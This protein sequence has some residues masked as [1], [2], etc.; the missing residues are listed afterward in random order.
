MN[1]TV[2]KTAGTGENPSRE[3][4]AMPV[5]LTIAGSDSGGGAGIQA[6][7]KTFEAFGVFGC[8]AITVLTAQNSTGVQAIHP[9]PVPFVLAQIE[10]VLTDFDVAAIKLGMLYNQE[11]I[12]A[13]AAIIKP[14]T[15]PVVLDPVCVSKAGSPLIQKEAIAAL[16]DL[17]RVVTLSTPNQHEANRLFGYEGGE[18]DLPAILLDHPA[19]VLIKHHTTETMCADMLYSGA[20]KRVYVADLID[21]TSVHGT[22]CSYSSAI[23]AS[24]ALG[25]DLDAAIRRSKQFITEAIRYAPA[26]GHGRGPINHKQGGIHLAERTLC[27][28]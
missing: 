4:T 8:S 27:H 16:R 1:Q 7:L 18:A 12:E 21:S 11:I 26:I 9:L 15:I 20:V 2:E 3:G 10:S 13:V 14:L 17:C 28:H 5:V 6:D 25:F 19:P 22:G 24:L 23:A